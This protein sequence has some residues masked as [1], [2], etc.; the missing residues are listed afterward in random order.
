M[1][2]RNVGTMAKS[3]GERVRTHN[4]ENGGERVARVSIEGW[5]VPPKNVCD[6][7][8]RDGVSNRCDGVS[9]GCDRCGGR[10]GHVLDATDANSP[11]LNLPSDG[12]DQATN[13]SF[14][15]SLSHRRFI[16]PTTAS[17]A[18][19]FPY[20]YAFLQFPSVDFP[21]TFVTISP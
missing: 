7:R 18:I 19:A 11:R 20:S 8:G 6:A 2:R 12:R 5:R 9:R 13:F 3:K 1:G 4:E 16:S 14:A 17:P 21:A 10:D 15:S